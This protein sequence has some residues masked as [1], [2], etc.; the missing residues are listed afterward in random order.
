MIKM[1]VSGEILRARMIYQL[2][3]SRERTYSQDHRS[4]DVDIWTMT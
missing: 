3:V 1:T 4:I 2:S